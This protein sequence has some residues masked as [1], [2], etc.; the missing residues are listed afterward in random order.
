MRGLRPD[1]ASVHPP[2]APSAPSG[3]PRSGVVA[4]PQRRSWGWAVFAMSIAAMVLLAPFSS[5]YRVLT[6]GVGVLL[7]GVAV[8]LFAGRRMW[9]LV[10]PIFLLAALL[11]PARLF[12]T[13]G[14]S[15]S[16]GVGDISLDGKDLGIGAA[17]PKHPVTQHL[18][19]GHMNVDLRNVAAAEQLRFTIGTGQIDIAVPSDVAVT[20][21]ARVGIGQI[22]FDDQPQVTSGGPRATVKINGSEIHGGSNLEVT[23]ELGPTDA[24]R[25]LDVEAKV[26]LGAIIVTRTAAEGGSK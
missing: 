11:I 20:I 15:L 6:V 24:V 13:A 4:Q 21:H 16:G 22:Q 18:A 25:H 3:A 7:V 19:A 12:G 8:G 2:W 26:G 5:V 14:V 1:A 9:P 23:R 17:D 10:I